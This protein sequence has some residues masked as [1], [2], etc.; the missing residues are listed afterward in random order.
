MS[1]SGQA[2][3]FD[4]VV[5]D[6]YK[7]GR[8]SPLRNI[9][10]LN[11]PVVI[12]TDMLHTF[13]LGIGGDLA[14]SGVV[15]LAKMKLFQGRALQAQLDYAYDLFDEWCKINKKTPTTKAFEKGKF[16]MSTSHEPNSYVLVVALGFLIF[17]DVEVK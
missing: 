5:P 13:N 6:P 14:S 16:H 3:T 17:G 12:K 9:P 15:A 11:N 10:G 8:M 1:S 7:T 4:G 2:R